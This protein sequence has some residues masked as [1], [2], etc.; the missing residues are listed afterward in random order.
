[1][2]G[3]GL[4][5]KS[6]NGFIG[7]EDR[8]KD[9]F[10]YFSGHAGHGHSSV[11]FLVEKRVEEGE[12]GLFLRYCTVVKPSSSS[13]LESWDS[14]RCYWAGGMDAGG[15]GRVRGIAA[16]G[17]SVSPQRIGRSELQLSLGPGSRGRASTVLGGS[18]EPFLGAGTGAG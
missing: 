2:G 3:I 6:G 5:C 17:G 13:M 15:V 1:M 7:G 9:R 11:S 12:E 14:V 8:T 18:E 10:R 16:G 4:P